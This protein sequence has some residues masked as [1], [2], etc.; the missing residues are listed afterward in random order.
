[1]GRSRWPCYAK[2]VF[3]AAS[4]E[5]NIKVPLSGIC[6]CTPGT[7]R[8]FYS[9]LIINA[10]ASLPPY[11]STIRQFNIQTPSMLYFHKIQFFHNFIYHEF[12]SGTIFQYLKISF[13]FFLTKLLTN[14]LYFHELK[15]HKICII[16]CN[17]NM[18][19]FV[20]ITLRNN[21]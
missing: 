12:Y 15:M 18:G 16:L 1:M 17:W 20:T 6:E 21:S 9:L 11:T 2:N 8:S 4:R 3:Q 10:Y 19:R 14:F 5:K 7:L 13:P